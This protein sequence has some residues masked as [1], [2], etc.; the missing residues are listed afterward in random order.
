MFINLVLLCLTHLSLLS[1]LLF[2]WIFQ[3]YYYHHQLQVSACYYPSEYNGHFDKLLITREEIQSRIKVLAQQLHKDY[4]GTRPVMV[5]TLKGA[6]PFYQHLLDALQELK[7]GYYMEFI[8][9]SSYLGTSSTGE[10]S[11]VGSELSETEVRNRHVILVEDIVDTGTTIANLVPMVQKFNPKSV[12]VCTLLEKRLDDPTTIKAK[13]KYTGFSI[14]NS[15]IVGYGLDYNEL[16]R[17]VR[18]IWVI[19]QIGINFD[20][21]TL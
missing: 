9:A 10:V 14:P 11:I 12:E 19:S 18:D 4:G 21:K 17:D 13:A 8:R 15:F 1:L 20:A 5:C 2:G 16:Y 6:C 3:H 7:Q